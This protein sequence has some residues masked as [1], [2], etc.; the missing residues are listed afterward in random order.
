MIITSLLLGLIGAAAFLAAVRALP[1]KL[2]VMAAGLIVAALLYVG[3]A[4]AGGAGAARIA[5][6]AVGVGIY[7][8]LA[9]IGLR[10]SAWWLM[11]GWLLHP[12]WDV[13]LHFLKQ[14]AA[15]APVWYVLACVSFDLLVAAYITW[16][17]VR[18]SQFRTDRVTD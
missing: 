18:G 6:E 5:L 9:L 17:T 16:S 10:Y 11:L 15:Y 14:G 1:Q 8:L 4:I 12:V 2:S 13:G 7:G 3:F